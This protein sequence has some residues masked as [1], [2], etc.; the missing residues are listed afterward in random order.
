MITQL[1]LTN[2]VFR[3]IEALHCSGRICFE[4]NTFGLFDNGMVRLTIGGIYAEQSSST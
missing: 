1:R 4:I 2:S 3:N